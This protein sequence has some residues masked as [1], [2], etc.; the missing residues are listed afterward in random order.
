MKQEKVS[1]RVVPDIRRMK[2]ESRFPLKLRITYKGDRKYYGTGYDATTEE[3]ETINSSSASGDLRKIKNEIGSTEKRA[4]KK[5]EEI[6][7]FSFKQFE[8]EFFE[9]RIRYEN[10]KSAFDAYIHQLKS[11]EQWGTATS[12]QTA[13]NALHKFRPKIALEDINKE[14]L[15]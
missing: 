2:G 1:V 12:Y 15:Q 5:A 14:F 9:Q 4:L 3:W 6:V 11:N 7:P 13:C 8:K 10:L